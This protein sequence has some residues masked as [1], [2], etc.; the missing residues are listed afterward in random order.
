MTTERRQMGQELDGQHIAVTGRLASMNRP[1]AAQLIARHGGRYGPHVNRQT[2]LLVVGREAWPLQYDGQLTRKLIRARQLRLRGQDLQVVPEEA[3][4]RLLALP[5]LASEVC[6]SYTLGELTRLLH[7]P[8]QRIES[9]QRNGLL[10][11]AVSHHE[12]PCFDFRQVAAARS[13]QKLLASGVSPRRVLRS[14]CQ[15]QT[16]FATNGEPAELLS[17]LRHDGRRVVFRTESGRL[18][19]PTG[20]LLF[21]YDGAEMLPTVPWSV[22]SAGDRL[23]EEAVQWEQRGELDRAAERYRRLLLEEGPDADVCF[24]LGNVLS[25]LREKQAAI[26][27]FHEAVML[28]PRHADAWNNLAN[29]LAEL[30]RLD[31]ARSAYSRAVE[32]DPE[33]A[34][35][36]YGLADVLEQLGR[37]DDARVHWRSY[38]QYEPFGPWADYARTRLVSQAI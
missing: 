2:T 9:W 24:N 20:Q 7:V 32:A 19:E 17:R 8:R 10:T 22:P 31:E 14:L 1:A 12:I 25:Q 30:N 11:P 28:D 26:E 5:H 23:F 16:W 27:R 29:L 6:Q 4:L 37:L 18:T 35:A 34:D 36:H 3:F 38:L 15:M 13:L 33:Y 21:E